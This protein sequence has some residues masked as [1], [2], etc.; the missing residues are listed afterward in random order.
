MVS[1][2]TSLDGSVFSAG[3]GKLSSIICFSPTYESSELLVPELFSLC[4]VQTVV[5]MLVS[6]HRFAEVFSKE[7]PHG[8]Q[9]CL[10]SGLSQ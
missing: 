7:D 8:L 6:L 3:T 2:M 4:F 9:L 5:R 10:R 1:K